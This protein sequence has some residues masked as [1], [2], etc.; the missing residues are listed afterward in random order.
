MDVYCL[1]FESY[2]ETRSYYVM[3]I[4]FKHILTHIPGPLYM[5]NAAVDVI[6]TGG[7]FWADISSNKHT[8]MWG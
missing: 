2:V 6:G 4:S 7:H 1:S 3:E 8:A 5:T